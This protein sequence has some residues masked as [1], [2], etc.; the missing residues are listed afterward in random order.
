MHTRR[1]LTV[2]ELGRVCSSL[3]GEMRLLF[4]I[5]IYTGLRL[6]DAVKIEWGNIDLVRGMISLVP[7]KT[8]KHTNGKPVQIPLHVTLA[9]MLAEVPTEERTGFVL[10]ELAAMYNHDAA[11]V[12]KRIQAVFETNGIKTTSSVKSESGRAQIDVGFHSLRHT[13][14]SL[15]ANAGV[16]LAIV[17]A[18]VGHSNPAM[19]RHY[20]HESEQALKSAVAAL[21]AI[22]NTAAPAKAAKLPKA[23]LAGLARLSQEQ[24][25]AARAE[26]DQRIA[27]CKP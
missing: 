9:S 7:H 22:G 24:L 14:V 1:E 15:S 17:Q 27:H 16:P 3:S 23:L 13:F 2:E 4:A 12:S 5:G 6:G 20:F 21:P 25:V 26:I 19:T 10:P 8:R 18:I 11:S